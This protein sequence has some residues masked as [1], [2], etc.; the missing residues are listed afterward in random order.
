MQR[1]PGPPG[2][3]PGLGLLA[4][5]GATMPK[6]LN[7]REKLAAKAREHF[8]KARQLREQVNAGIAKA[9]RPDPFGTP[10]PAT[11]TD[12]AERAYHQE[13]KARRPA[14]ADATRTRPAK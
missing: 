7:A 4:F 12:P 11:P 13:G 8:R 6:K 2:L 3:I 10:A 14:A 5:P 9:T 1:P